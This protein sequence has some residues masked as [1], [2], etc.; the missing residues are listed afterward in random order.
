MITI[1]II[2]VAITTT[3]TI[4]NCGDPHEIE[5]QAL[6]RA[7]ERINVVST[8]MNQHCVKSPGIVV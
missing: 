2:P 1:V 3:I 4:S 5:D 8:I 7:G 6:H